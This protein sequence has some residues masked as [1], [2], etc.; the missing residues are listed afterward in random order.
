MN[1][2]DT[3]GLLFIIF[4]NYSNFVCNQHYGLKLIVLVTNLNYYNVVANKI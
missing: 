2:E 1:Y 3:P 4:G